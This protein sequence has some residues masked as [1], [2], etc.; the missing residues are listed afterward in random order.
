[1]NSPSLFFPSIV[2]EGWTHWFGTANA[3]FTRGSSRPGESY[4]RVATEEWCALQLRFSW[5]AHKNLTN[6][7]KHR[8]SFEVAARVFIDA[9]RI[10]QYDD[11]EDYGE[12]RWITIGIAGWRSWLWSTPCAMNVVKSSA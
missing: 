3:S 1:L 12:D 4:N 10:E 9:N 6:Q 7:R 5:D 2:V 11:Q 8:V